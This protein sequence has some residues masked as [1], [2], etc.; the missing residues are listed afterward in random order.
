MKGIILIIIMV[1][2]AS[3]GTKYNYNDLGICNDYYDGSIYEYLRHDKGNWDSITKVIDKCSPE[4]KALLE[5][6]KITFFGPKNIAFQKYFFWGNPEH[7]SSSVV[8]Y[9][10]E[11]YT[12]IDDMPRELCDS[13][14]KSHLVIG[15]VM[16]DDVPRVI[17]DEEKKNIGGGSILTTVGG[18]KIWVWTIRNAYAGV[19]D[20]GDVELLLASVKADGKTV[21]NNL[22]T[23][24]TTNIRAENGVV[25]ALSDAYFLGQLFEFEN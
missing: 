19:E 5:N 23:I 10:V 21:I 18:N 14:V 1:I 22:G 17:T 16:R 9:N 20:M 3:C 2:L 11:G 12:C 7:E 24:A 25:Q 6:E 8:N 13:I 15:V 4:V